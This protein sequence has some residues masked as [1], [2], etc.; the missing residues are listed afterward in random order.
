MTGVELASLTAPV[1]EAEPC[2]SDLDL[3]GDPDFLNF[4]AKAE[5]VLPGSYFSARDGKP[6]DRGSIDFATELEG[7]KP[8]LERTRDLRLLVTLAKFHI[9]NRDVAAFQTCV[10]AIGALLGTQ[11]N[12]VHPR[13]EEGD[14]TMRMAAI[15]TLDDLPTVVYPLQ[16]VPLV[17]HRRLGVI[18]YRNYMTAT[19]EIKP[20]ED[21]EQPLDLGT[22]DKALMEAELPPLV[23]TLRQFEALQTAFGNIRTIWIEHA[24][25]DQAVNLVKA[26]QTIGNIVSLVNGI[27]AKRDPS[28]ARQTDAADSAAAGAAEAVSGQMTNRADAAEALAGVADYFARAEPSNPALLLVRQAQQLIGRSFAQVMQMLVPTH[29]EQAAIAI[30]AQYVFDL[31]IERLSTLDAAAPVDVPEPA[32]EAP[33][34][35]DPTPAQPPPDEDVSSDVQAA[36]EAIT[37]DPPAAELTNEDTQE[38]RGANGS[39][40]SDPSGT[41]PL[42]DGAAG[43]RRRVKVTT[44]Q[45]AF[46]LLDQVAAYYRA[47]EPTSPISVIVERARFVADRDFMS[48]LKDFLPESTLRSTISE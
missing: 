32:F 42:S 7:A 24:G 45:Q 9:L 30:G 37:N 19:G 8:L 4:M 3:D 28:A 20:R 15:E 16:F 1:S 44:R 6:F 14:Y 10:E 48:L 25:F 34:P 46:V 31:P 26:T 47:A 40:A 11:W 18:A 17:N 21:E 43:Q 13:G 5:G 12:H 33:P 23:E 22:I 36:E 39:A 38:P 35:E 29:F 41:T 2:G 27:V